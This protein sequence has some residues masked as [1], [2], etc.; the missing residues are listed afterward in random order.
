MNE[1]RKGGKGKEGE[2]ENG[3]MKERKDLEKDCVQKPAEDA[4]EQIRR[5]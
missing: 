1:K 4:L 5:V 2:K 3:W